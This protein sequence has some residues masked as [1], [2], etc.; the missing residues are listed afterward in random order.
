MNQVF[1]GVTVFKNI[2]YST[3]VSFVFRGI[4]RGL[5]M[6]NEETGPRLG[7]RWRAVYIL[8]NTQCS[9]IETKISLYQPFEC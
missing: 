9:K 6:L 4:R 7:V 3:L 2:V 5:K 8:C 1:F